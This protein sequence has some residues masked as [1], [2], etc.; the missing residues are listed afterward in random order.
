MRPR[1]VLLVAGHEIAERARSRAYLLSTAVLVLA[2][3]VA[4]AVPHLLRSADRAGDAP[5]AAHAADARS[6]AAKSPDGARSPDGGAGQVSSASRQLATDAQAGRNLAY[7]AAILLYVALIFAG[8]WVGSG[9]V[10]EKSSRVVEVLLSALRPA[11]LLCGKLI[12][13]GVVAFA[14]VAAAATGAATVAIAI[15]D[16]HLPHAIS[17]TALMVVG[18][19]VLGYALYACAFAVAASLVSRQEDVPA[20]TTPLNVLMAAAFL[21]A[22]KVAE[23]PDGLTAHVL[24]FVPPF[25][26]LLMPVRAAAGELPASEQ[27]LA[28]TLCLATTVVLLRIAV[29]VYGGFALRFGAPTRLRSALRAGTAGRSRQ[30]AA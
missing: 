17:W 21:T 13:I 25:S 28:V 6:G 16:L 1:S 12:G 29:R 26:P 2:A 3:C 20:V 30:G 14:Q 23:Q 22:M 24:S 10:E 4:L 15:G 27:L 9:I 7:G 8:T 5:V 19:F 11:E 18:W